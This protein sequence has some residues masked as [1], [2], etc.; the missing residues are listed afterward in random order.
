MKIHSDESHPAGFAI[1]ADGAFLFD[2]LEA[3]RFEQ[4][5]Q[6]VKRHRASSLLF[7]IAR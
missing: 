7:S 5:D 6:L 4:S 1:I 3:I 2:Q